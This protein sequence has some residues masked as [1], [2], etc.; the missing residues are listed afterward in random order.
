MCVCVC[1]TQVTPMELVAAVKGDVA[2]SAAVYRS[3]RAALMP[4]YPTFEA[5]CAA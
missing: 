1:A 3:F 2:L 4:T 5:L